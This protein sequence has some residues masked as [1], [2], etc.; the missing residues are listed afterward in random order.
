MSK[1]KACR[2]V[3]KPPLRMNISGDIMTRYVQEC[4]GNKFKFFLDKVECGDGKQY[5]FTFIFKSRKQGREA[6]K[7]LKENVKSTGEEIQISVL[8]EVEEDSSTAARTASFL[9]KCEREIQAKIE[10]LTEHHNIKVQEIVRRLEDLKVRKHVSL[11]E[12]E[13]ISSKREAL[14]SKKREL[15]KQGEEFARFGCHVKDVLHAQVGKAQASVEQA[16]KNLRN[17][18]GRECHRLDAALPMYAKKSLIIETIKDN[19]VCVVLGETGSGKST[20]M[21]Q[22]LYEAGFAEKG[23][24]VC[25]Q[26]R[27]VA[28]TS[29][30][31]HVAH[32]MGGVRGQ[33]VG[34]HV[35]GN[36]QAGK[37]TRIM[38]AT[39]HVLLNECLKDPN[40]SKYSCIIID[41][42]HERSIYS[43]LLLGMIKKT[44]T[45][46][47]DLR[48][49]I[50]S[51]TIDP[52]LFVSYFNECP[53]LKV[54]G[55]MFP[56]HVTWKDDSSHNFEDY[57]R[58]AVD[59]VR[60]IH[61]KEGQ[62]DILVFLTSPAE[63]ERA[64]ENLSKL[65]P[66]TNLVCLPL[67]GK[68]R[69]EEQRKVFEFLP[70][71]RKVVFATNCAETSIT[72]PGIKYVVDS[73]MVKEMKYDAKR[74][75]SSLEVTTIS[76]SSAEQRKGRAGRTQEGKCYRLYSEDEYEAL[77]DRSRPEI[78]RVHLGQAVLK[79]LDLGIEDI[80]Q[81]DFVE[82]PPQE[83]IELAL[84][85]LTSLGAIERGAL[86]ALGRK[87]ARVPVEPRL[88]KLIFDGID[89]NVGTESV[90]LAAVATVSGSLF[91]RMGSD[92][93]RE[94]ADSRKIRFCHNGGDLLTMLEVF[95]QYLKQPKAKRNKWAFD[96]SLNAKSLR[97]TEETVKELKL[98][99][100]HELDVIVPDAAF[101]ENGNIDETMQ[102][103]L[104]D[105]YVS[106]LAVYTGHEKTGYRIVSSNQSVQIHPSS[107][108]NFLGATPQFVVF[109]QLLK[110]SR[111]FAI[112]TTPIEESW[113]C[114]MISVGRVSYTMDDL[115]STVMS[116]TSLPCSPDLM[117]L[118]FGGSRRRV[119][120]DLE[121]E[122]SKLCDD[123]FVVLEKDEK[124]GQI[125]VFALPIHVPKALYEVEKCLEQS[126]RVLRCEDKEE[127]LKEGCEGT[128]IVWG[129]AGEVQDV[130]MPHMYRTV[131]VNDVHDSQ[132]VINR[133]KS[134]GEVVKHH[135]NEGDGK[136]RVFVTF[137]RSEDAYLAV[138]SSSEASRDFSFDV[139]PNHSISNGV[140]S[141]VSGFR[142]EV[143][144]CRRLA[145]GTG[146]IKF[147]TPED[148]FHAFGRLSPSRVIGTSLVKF[149]PD[150]IHP[151]QI[152]MRGLHPRA[153]EENVKAT[154]EGMVPSVKIKKIFIHRKPEFE[155]TD[156]EVAL[157]KTS[158]EKYL[159]D[160]ATEGKFSVYVRKPKSKDFE[161]QAY[162]TFEDFEEGQA[163]LKGLNGR[164]IPGFGILT[165]HCSLSTLLL[166]PRNVFI[167]IKDE[168]DAI[169]T[170]VK[171]RF[172]TTFVLT[173]DQQQS[174]RVAVEIRSECADH[175]IRV[176]S[177]VSAILNG[178]EIDCKISKDVEFLLTDSAKKAIQ[179][180]QNETNTV[181]SQ[182][183]RNKVVR[184]HGQQDKREEAKRAINKFIGDLIASNSHFWQIGLRG[185]G[186]PRGLLKALFERFGVD[187]HGLQDI[188]GVQN[189]T[190]EF[191]RHVLKIISSD[192]AQE[193][194][195]GFVNECCENLPKNCPHQGDNQ[196]QSQAQLA[197]GICLCD[198]EDT[199]EIYRLA[200]CGHAYDKTCIIQQ[201][202]SAVVP[203]KCVTENCEEPVVWKDLQ[204]LLSQS[205]R[206]KLLISSLDAYVRCNP[207]S[208]KYCPTPD[209]G[210][211]YRVS[212]DG[213]SHKCGACSADI[214]TS[215]HTQSHRGLT[216]AMFK[217]GRNVEEDFKEWMRKDPSNR[218]N[219]P[220][221][222]APIEKNQG[223]NHMECSQC[224][225]HMCWLCLGVFR[226]GHEVYDHQSHC[227]N[228]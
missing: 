195:K 26:P 171:Q 124:V 169:V 46:R 206:K 34:C 134:F 160:F 184:I 193:T 100:K 91:F 127:S 174:K 153:S 157:Q 29:L 212:S 38:Y 154:I 179:T 53:V 186:M 166:C 25:T 140:H 135:L 10:A 47:P 219:C 74:N 172:G 58:A 55:R 82:A 150:R 142:V 152:F 173:K 52:S 175:F 182:D 167:V 81:F 110:T 85:S 104:I 4:V 111:D 33:I 61:H 168:L 114:E 130:L 218:K 205:E 50:T 43:D 1:Q 56:V 216:C 226:T 224:K 5:Q 209:C 36:I 159:L 86:T 178:D 72:I 105:C 113:L 79:L 223:C 221:C 222:N 39:D 156:E 164:A 122:V 126:R 123:S 42:A 8:K 62:G 97:L 60:E 200:C 64:C 204:N 177:I 9:V 165:L 197:C 215:C 71:K 103:I 96:N 187:L 54:S 132:M 125:N 220:Q 121:E 106:N 88:A 225:A 228:K 107:A 158:I 30:A 28:A 194:I 63:T 180:I 90:A 196:T 185:P 35:G 133:L 23:T 92:K 66:D 102:R 40:L 207:D 137:K 31:D 12:Y 77:E 161:G 120:G 117:K 128:R 210:T 80:S 199:D 147:C 227:P 201:L 41:E 108:L 7:I 94:L 202:K 101:H 213:R 2:L 87:I 93:E 116:R 49:V 57:L 198:L 14:E 99:L 68:L 21:T 78:L 67:H 70:D 148:Y 191:R 16:I 139:R 144:W 89:Q 83:S 217:S 146:S 115:K 22:Y 163:A 6:A 214:C 75:K 51:A 188:S 17:Y 192:E 145:K 59:T 20:Q 208:V 69:Q 131:T 3:I 112:N 45:R 73:G 98:A 211:V 155:T 109:E 141:Q 32:E 13:I 203:L 37:T 176:T 189:V 44:L 95:R 118:A 170:E 19:Q 119:L 129:P 183:W 151:E 48:V 181:I 65:E 11:S 143:K 24:I 18:L 84:K 162:V 15:E 27:K 190:V 136:S 76:K 149:Q 138:K